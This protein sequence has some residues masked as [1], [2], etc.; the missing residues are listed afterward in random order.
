MGISLFLNWGHEI[1]ANAKAPARKVESPRSKDQRLEPT[2]RIVLQSENT[3]MPHLNNILSCLFFMFSALSLFAADK[4][5]DKPLYPCGD[6]HPASAG[7]CAT[8]PVATHTVLPEYTEAAR[9]AKLAGRVVLSLVVNKKGLPSDVHVVTSLGQGL[10]EQAMAAVERWKFTPGTYKDHSVAVTVK[11]PLYFEHCGSARDSSPNANE[12]APPTHYLFPAPG[13]EFSILESN[14]KNLRKV[15]H[16]YD[17]GGSIGVSPKMACAPALIH[18]PNPR[19]TEEAKRVGLQGIVLV[20][21][22]VNQHGNVQD[23]HVVQSIGQPVDDEA[24]AAAKQWKFRPAAYDDLPVAVNA[25]A[26]LEFG[27]C[28]TFTVSAGPV[29]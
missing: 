2:A 13:T 4:S 3:D 17:C 1:M 11:V 10:D 5:K 12:D 28:R 15:T 20:S 27:E 26:A 16:L 14:D 9:Q 6:E 29:E 8:T 18:A 23:V 21:L 24:V 7:A 19:Y 25:Y 22:V